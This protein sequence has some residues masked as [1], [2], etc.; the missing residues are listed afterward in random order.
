MATA[1]LIGRLGGPPEVVTTTL[2]GTTSIDHNHPQVTVPPGWGS[3]WTI[4]RG[5]VLR[6]RVYVTVFD[7]TTAAKSG[8]TIAAYTDIGGGVLLQAG[9]STTIGSYLQGTLTQI[10]MS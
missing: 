5:K 7:M 8:G 2:T 1:R 3:A 4:F 10:R 6:D 9:Q